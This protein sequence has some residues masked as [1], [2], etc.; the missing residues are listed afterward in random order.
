M[1]NN[2]S[3]KEQCFSILGNLF[4]GC[5]GYCDTCQYNKEDLCY[6]F[7]LWLDRQI[8]KTENMKAQFEYIRDLEMGGDRTKLTIR[9]EKDVTAWCSN[10]KYSETV[11]LVND[12]L[13]PTQKFFQRAD[14]KICH[15]CGEHTYGECELR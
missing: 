5:S 3:I 13:T 14:S 6:I 8:S 11:S 9:K 2:N 7:S 1:V 4:G 15:V 10:C 12:K